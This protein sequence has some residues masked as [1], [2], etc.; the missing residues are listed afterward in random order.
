MI[1]AETEK[2]CI[3]NKLAEQYPKDLKAIM[4]SAEGRRVFSYLLMTC[5]VD[6]TN[7]RGNSHDFFNFGMRSVAIN[8]LI[9]G[10]NSLG[11]EGV[12]LKQKAEKEYI[13]L[14]EAFLQDIRKQAE[15]EFK[16]Q[17]LNIKR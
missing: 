8:Y 13:M 2:Q 11:I 5:G 3:L 12:E 7:M 9:G 1:P 14:Q 15:V 6:N 16:K 17:K 4:Q 10:T